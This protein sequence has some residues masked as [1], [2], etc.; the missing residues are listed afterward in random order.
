MMLYLAT[1]PQQPVMRRIAI[2]VTLARG[3]RRAVT[4]FIAGAAG[5]LAMAPFDFF[6]AIAIPMTA[7]IWLID[8]CAENRQQPRSVLSHAGLPL[9][10]WRA[11]MA[12]WWWGF[13]YFVAGIWWL[14]AAFLVDAKEFAWALPFGVAGLP[15]ALAIY[16]GLGFML[17]RLIWPRGA[18]R[19]FA[20]AAAMSFAEWLRGHLVTG[21]PWNLFGMA[22]GGNLLTAQ[23]ASLIGLYG[24]TIVVILIFSAPATLSDKRAAT[25][26][27]RRVPLP[28]AA[29]VLAFG[30]TCGFGVVRLSA[31]LP[32]LIPGVNLRIMQPNL[33]QDE[34][35]RAENGAAILAHYLALSTHAPEGK[36]PGLDGIRLLLWPES[37]FPFV[38]SRAPWALSEITAALP[39]GTAL[40]TGAARMGGGTQTGSRPH[41]RNAIQV[42]ASGGQILGSYDKMHLVPFGEY[43]PFQSLFDRLG[44]RQF[45]H[46]PGGFEAGNGPRSLAIPGV[47]PA[48]PLICYEVIFPDEIVPRGPMQE[49]PG[50]LLNVTNDGWF[51]RTPGP[52]QH[53]AQARLRAIEE[54]LPLVRAANTGISAIVDPFG[55]MLGHLPLGEQGVLDGGLPESIAAPAFAQFPNI[56]V[57]A[58]WAAVLSCAVLARICT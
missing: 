40:V 53:F 19:L 46:I 31:P 22:L 13:G 34:K 42:I 17:A 16:S 44:L 58:L 29:A 23:L 6:P 18:A 36:G 28:F 21:F 24:L 5:A 1:L 14:G 52:Y 41:Y 2:A 35:F 39:E 7:A 49:R 51:G 12:G 20:F 10:A 11:F 33:A 4:A 30:G 32:K 50:V 43:L 37:A 9:S 57:F 27:L 8:G 26:F 15:A 25:T 45:V 47:P 54:G 56:I 38:L 55:R 3:W 48:M